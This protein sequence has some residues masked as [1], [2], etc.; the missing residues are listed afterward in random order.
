MR[1]YHMRAVAIPR[2]RYA[3]CYSVGVAE[4]TQMQVLITHTRTKKE[5]IQ[6]R[7]KACSECQDRTHDMVTNT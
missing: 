4:T 5:R 3:L 1:W 7:G 2:C 6:L